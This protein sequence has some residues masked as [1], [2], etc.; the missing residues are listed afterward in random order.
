[1][2]G[3]ELG[4]IRPACDEDAQDLFGLLALCFAEYPG[5]FVDP[6]D[7]LADLLRPARAYAER[8][9][10]FWVIDDARGRACACVAIDCPEWG[11]AEMHRL[12]V[13]P[14]RRR[15]GLGQA[16]VE[17]VEREARVGGATLL[18]LWSDTRFTAA[19]RLYERLGYGRTGLARDLG[20]LSRST[21]HRFEKRL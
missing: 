9:G 12:Y 17:R 14:D 4:D 8:G 21:E 2:R 6:H 10:H 13:R 5:C 20:D 16:L 11:A 15:T 18:M 19:H 3:P 7:D 1:M